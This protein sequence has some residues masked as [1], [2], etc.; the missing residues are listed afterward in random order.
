MFVLAEVKSSTSGIALIYQWKVMFT[1]GNCQSSIGAG[2][3]L[4]LVQLYYSS[5]PVLIKLYY[6]NT[7]VI[8]QI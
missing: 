4:Q 7:T 8:L 1:S 3:L 6:S 5:T 2:I